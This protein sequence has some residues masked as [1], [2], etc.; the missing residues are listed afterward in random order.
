MKANAMTSILDI[1][2]DYFRFFDDPLNRL[3]ELLDWAT[4]PVDK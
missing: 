3:N 4:R 1:D 2:L